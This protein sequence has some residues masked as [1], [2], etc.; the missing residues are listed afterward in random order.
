MPLVIVAFYYFLYPHKI[1]ALRFIIKRFFQSKITIGH[2]FIAGGLGLFLLLYI[3]RS[4]NYHF[5]VLGFESGVR[6]VLGD[7]LLVRPRTKEFLIGYPVLFFTLTYLGRVISY[8]NKWFFY[9]L[10]TVAPVSMLNTFCHFHAPLWLSAM[11]S[12]NGFVLGV[13]IGIAAVFV[14]KISERIWKV[15]F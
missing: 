10:A 9:T 2:V 7:L 12:F 14:Y 11:R 15:I 1:S 3:L 4:G 6:K 13:G 8:Q 5:P